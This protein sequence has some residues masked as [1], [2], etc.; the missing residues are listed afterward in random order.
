MPNRLLES[1]NKYFIVENLYSINFI[2]VGVIFEKTI[3][4]SAMGEHNFTT[5]Q[6]PLIFN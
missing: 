2:K 5:C 3:Y 1:F 6:T 4:A